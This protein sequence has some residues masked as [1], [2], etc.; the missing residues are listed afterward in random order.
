MRTLSELLEQQ[1]LNAQDVIAFMTSND[2]PVPPN[3]LIEKLKNR[4]EI[5]K[6][7]QFLD[8][9]AIERERQE[10]IRMLRGLVPAIA[11]QVGAPRPSESVGVDY[12]GSRSIRPDG[13]CYYRAIMYRLLEQIIL[14]RDP[15]V[16]SRVLQRLQERVTEAFSRLGEGRLDRYLNSRYGGNLKTFGRD[17]YQDKLKN[18][19]IKLLNHQTS[20]NTLDAFLAD[21]RAETSSTDSELVQT[22]RIMTALASLEYLNKEFLEVND[23]VDSLM[24][25]R[26]AQGAPVQA[27]VLP[28]F[29]GIDCLIKPQIGDDIIFN[30]SEESKLDDVVVFNVTLKLN[31]SKADGHYDLLYTPVEFGVFSAVDIVEPAAAPKP[32]APLPNALD[33]LLK[34][35]LRIP[36]SQELPVAASS[37]DSSVV[38]KMTASDVYQEPKKAVG[39]NSPANVLAL[40]SLEDDAAAAPQPAARSVFDA[41]LPNALER[42]PRAPLIL[43]EKS[44]VSEP[45][46]RL[47]PI[48]EHPASLSASSLEDSSAV[49]EIPAAV[50]DNVQSQSANHNPDSIDPP[51]VPPVVSLDSSNAGHSWKR[52]LFFTA[53]GVVG[54]AA[55][56]YGVYAGLTAMKVALSSVIAVSAFVAAPLIAAALAAAVYLLIKHCQSNHSPALEAL[57]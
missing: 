10:R 3:E 23:I 24:M 14:I 15:E 53:S 2:L 19:Y 33:R 43:G 1:T 44:T 12:P 40:A 45:P 18:V 39:D 13:N 34:V 5:G 48:D 56:E 25:S 37:K 9:Q 55:V 8:R 20:W 36:P 51:T 57:P 29:L 49:P 31:N 38:P 42:P 21:I 6:V 46:N 11:S 27:F 16:K 50:V 52:N 47:E 41:P 28:R 26:Y 17:F 22:A 54:L 32:A 30:A 4:V 35:P 7:Q